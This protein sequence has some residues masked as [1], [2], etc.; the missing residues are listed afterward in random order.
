MNVELDTLRLHPERMSDFGDDVDELRGV[1][2]LAPEG[3]WLQNQARLNRY[4][5]VLLDRFE[6]SPL[7][8]GSQTGA[9]GDDEDGL[10]A[11]TSGEQS[12]FRAA[13]LEPPS[14]YNLIARLATPG[15]SGFSRKLLRCETALRLAE[16]ACA[17]ER[18][19]L[20]H[21]SY[22]DALKE[23]V[24]PFLTDVPLDPVNHLPL[25]YQ[26]SADGWFRL[27]SIAA[28]ERDDQG[29]PEGTQPGGDWVWPTPVPTTIQDCSKEASCPAGVRCFRKLPHN[30]SRRRKAKCPGDEGGRTKPGITVQS[31][32]RSSLPHHPCRADFAVRLRINERFIGIHTRYAK[33]PIT[34][35]KSMVGPQPFAH[36]C[37]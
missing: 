36:L 16:T 3:W 25:H 14:P 12:L 37:Q 17:L 19:R 31:Q 5:M 8:A 21:G 7:L 4:Y 30:P 11:E 20:A 34:R 23:L 9:T 10:H 18:H 27:Y 26:K 2:R 24:G 28:D 15:L 29:R 35:R 1:F 6:A 22:P 33:G 32:V 13:G